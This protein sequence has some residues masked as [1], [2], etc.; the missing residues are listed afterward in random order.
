[1]LIIIIGMFFL[2]NYPPQAAGISDL[3]KATAT[4]NNAPSDGIKDPGYAM[5]GT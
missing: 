4:N 5:N 2:M 3:A 1:M